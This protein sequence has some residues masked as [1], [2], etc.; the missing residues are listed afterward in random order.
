MS[1]W[2]TVT[3]EQAWPCQPGNPDGKSVNSRDEEV[4]NGANH[5]RAPD[6]LPLG[7]A[8]RLGGLPSRRSKHRVDRVDVVPAAV[9]TDEPGPLVKHLQVLLA[10]VGGLELDYPGVVDFCPGDCV[11][12]L[13]PTPARVLRQVERCWPCRVVPGSKQPVRIASRNASNR[14]RISAS[15]V[16]GQVRL[17][18]SVTPPSLQPIFAVS[19]I[20][21]ER[22]AL[23]P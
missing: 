17:V 10:E 19:G 6:R 9:L 7:G 23:A 8:A 4:T 2:D 5:E 21:G 15:A 12:D 16:S 14:D 1:T 11:D 22:P 18:S 3:E 20:G 13:Q